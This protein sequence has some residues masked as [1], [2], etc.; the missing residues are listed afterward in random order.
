[1]LREIARRLAQVAR[2][3]AFFFAWT[4]AE[5]GSRFTDLEERLQRSPTPQQPGATDVDDEDHG[6]VL[7]VEF[8]PRAQQM[9][10]DALRIDRHTTNQPPAPLVGSP[11]HRLVELRKHH[12]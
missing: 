12:V 4:F 8:S 7:P 5:V 2:D 6:E 3:G 9:V 11:A 10:A 1:M